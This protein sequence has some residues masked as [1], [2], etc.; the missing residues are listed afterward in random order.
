MKLD[1]KQ[2]RS[3][4]LNQFFQ[5]GLIVLIAL[6]VRLYKISNPVLDWHA[7]RQA[8]TASVTRRFAQE[9]ID[10][11][12][13]R[14]HDLSNIQSGQPN[15]EGYRMVEFPLVNGLIAVLIRT[16]PQ[17]DLVIA[18]RF[19]SVLFSLGTLLSLYWLTKQISNRVMANLSA[20]FFALIPY[21]IFYSRVILP[22]PAMLCF[23]T[24][25]LA[26]F[27]YF[28]KTRNNWAWI[29]SLISLALAALLKP[30]ALF[31]APVYLVLALCYQ[32]H[33]PN[34]LKQ[35]KLWLYPAISIAPLLIWRDW[36]KKFPSGIPVSDWLFNSNQIRF[37]PAWFRWLFYERLA[38]LILGFV[39][40]IW[41]PINFSKIDKVFW[42]LVGW[43]GGLLAY[44]SIIA[45]GN[46]QH[47][48]YQVLA[49]PAL[50]LASGRGVYLAQRHFSKKIDN[51]LTK[52]KLPLHLCVRKKQ[53]SLFEQTKISSLISWLLILVIFLTQ[54]FFSWRVVKSYYQI[55]HYDYLKAGQAVNK[56]LP[57]DAKV[58]AP[59]NGDT[60]FLF[61]TKRNGWPLGV[62]IEDKIEEGATHYATVNYDN[63]AQDLEKKYITVKKTTDY[64]ILDLTQTKNE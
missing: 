11:A 29:G 53:P 21:S 2:L 4:A 37:K 51:L 63:V 27:V 3:I 24:L 7:F 50:C 26:A 46:V 44:L 58:I 60:M 22:E 28:L 56:L 57:P 42:I 14:Y 25:S 10:L 64:L 41:L 17:L 6:S 47:D 30:F 20:L 62:E 36:I 5:L 55:N 35:I 31:L 34:P 33:Q 18:S 12:K 54:L 19:I 39:G 32:P 38:K 40:L 23:S 43:A 15:P 8:D 52:L 61:Q 48:Y 16:L 49:I 59:A 1:Y 9:G 45:T 13:P